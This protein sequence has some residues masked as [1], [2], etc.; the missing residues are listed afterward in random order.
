[1]YDGQDIHEPDV[2]IDDHEILT[3]SQSMTNGILQNRCRFVDIFLILYSNYS[4]WDAMHDRLSYFRYNL[5]LTEKIH[6]S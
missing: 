3:S 1:M 4:I 6:F 5:T 2:M